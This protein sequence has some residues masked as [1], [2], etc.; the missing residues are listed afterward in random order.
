MR[1]LKKPHVTIRFQTA[2]EKFIAKGEVIQFDGFLKVYMESTDEDEDEGRGGNASPDEG[3]RE[4]GTQG[5]V[6]PAEIY[7]A[8]SAIYGS[9]PGKKLE[10]LGIGRPSTYAPTISTI[11][12]REYV[13]KEDRDGMR[14]RLHRCHPEKRENHRRGK[15]GKYGLKNQNCSR[16]ISAPWSTTSCAAF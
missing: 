9:Q 13:V 14:S 11:Q 6:R 12:K 3:R 16:P 15:N 1:S 8:A 5:D 4:T 7:A 2:T 10:E